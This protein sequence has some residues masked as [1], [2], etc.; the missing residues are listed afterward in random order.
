MIWAL[1]ILFFLSDRMYAQ[2]KHLMDFSELLQLFY[3]KC[4]LIVILTSNIRVFH[5]H[6]ALLKS[7]IITV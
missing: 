3:Y 6:I 5:K 7:N 1:S 2:R 4:V